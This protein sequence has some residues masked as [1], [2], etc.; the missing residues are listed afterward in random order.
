MIDAN[1][2]LDKCGAFAE[3]AGSLD[4]LHTKHPAPSTYIGS[5]TQSKAKQIRKG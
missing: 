4:D 1:E 5:Q 2:V 3:W